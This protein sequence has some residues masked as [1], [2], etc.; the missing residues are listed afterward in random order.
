MQ[1]ELC[2]ECQKELVAV[3]K[4]DRKEASLRG[5]M[6]PEGSKVPNDLSGVY[7]CA[8]H[9]AARSHTPHPQAVTQFLKRD[10]GLKAQKAR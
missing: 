8:E 6:F 7:H 10:S 2:R 5:A 1:R 4:A 3:S 9:K